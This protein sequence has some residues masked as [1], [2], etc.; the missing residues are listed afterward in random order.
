MVGICGDSPWHV[1]EVSSR[2]RANQRVVILMCQDGIAEF[3][4][5]YATHVTVTRGRSGRE[6]ALPEP[7]LRE[8]SDDMPL[9]AELRTFVQHLGGGPA[10][11]SSTG[12]GAAMVKVL[13]DLRAMAGLTA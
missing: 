12:E 2:R 10:P 9:L 6:K 13:A 8:L 7:E 11:R 1:L 4:E 5:P 3:C